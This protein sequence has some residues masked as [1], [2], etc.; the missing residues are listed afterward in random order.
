MDHELAFYFHYTT[1][2]IIDYCNYIKIGQCK[3]DNKLILKVKTNENV[4]DLCTIS[5]KPKKDLIDIHPCED[6]DIKDPW[7]CYTCLSAKDYFKYLDDFYNKLKNSKDEFI[8]CAVANELNDIVNR[9]YLFDP[10]H[11]NPL[12]KHLDKFLGRHVD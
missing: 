4:F 1:I 11:D 9:L 12:Q 2:L 3:N 10:M 5:Y 8:R 7:I 6:L